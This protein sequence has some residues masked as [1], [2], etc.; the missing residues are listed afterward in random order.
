MLAKRSN[1]YLRVILTTS[2]VPIAIA[3]IFYPK[4][5][6]INYTLKKSRA[7]IVII[8]THEKILM[9]VDF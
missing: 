3:A 8:I 2:T 5:N 1:L 6:L 7:I 9:K 4:F